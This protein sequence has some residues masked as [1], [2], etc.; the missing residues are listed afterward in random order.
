ME[1]PMPRVSQWV[2]N[3]CAEAGFVP[4]FKVGDYVRHPSGRWV[5]IVAGT[6]WG[7]SDISN[8]WEWREVRA[9]GSLG[10]VESGY[11][12]APKAA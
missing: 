7:D 12:W 9:D 3:F 10:P 6:Y 11:G 1:T 5:R 2:Q 8:H 4:P